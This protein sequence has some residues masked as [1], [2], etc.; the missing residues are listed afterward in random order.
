MRCPNCLSENPP[1]AKFCLECGNRLLVCPHCGTVNLPMAKFC[2]ECGSPLPSNPTTAS[3]SPSLQPVRTGKAQVSADLDGSSKI[4]L[5]APDERRVVTTM[6]ADIIGSTPL[7]DKLYD[8]FEGPS[9]QFANLYNRCP[10]RSDS[11]SCSFLLLSIPAFWRIQ[12]VWR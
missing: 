7:A 10:G 3:E 4:G 9:P 12:L 6:F 5:T 1:T 2:I 11:A 8:D